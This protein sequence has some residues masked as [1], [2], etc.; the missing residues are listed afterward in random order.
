MLGRIVDSKQSVESQLHLL[1][2]RYPET[3]YRRTEAVPPSDTE[4]RNRESE[5]GTAPDLDRSL[6]LD[7]PRWP[8]LHRARQRG[9]ENGV[10]AAHLCYKSVRRKGKS[11]K[12][13]EEGRGGGGGGW[14]WWE[15][16][17]TGKETN[18]ESHSDSGLFSL[19]VGGLHNAPCSAFS[20][21]ARPL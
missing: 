15:Q 4:T 8:R 3:E 7:H 9:H 21:E 1:K 13:E 16:R 5:H 12:K 6:D 14:R 2:S 10:S 18:S 19:V 20:C 11:R 17:G